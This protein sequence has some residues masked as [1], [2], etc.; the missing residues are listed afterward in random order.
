MDKKKIFIV[1]AAYNEGNS[2]AKVIGDLKSKGYRNIVVVDD[3]SR[4]NTYESA[5][6]AGAIVLRHI[7]NRGQGAGLKT[8]I[9]HALQ[10]NADIIVTYDADGQFL[11]S[12]I[13]RVADPVAKGYVDVAIGSR[14]LGEARNIPKLK[15]IVLKMGTF[16]LKLMY[17][18]NVTDSQNGFRAFSRNA[19]QQMEI[20]ADRME[21]A[22]EIL[23]EIAK[24][25]MRFI[26]IPVTV[27]YN[28]YALQKGQSWTRFAYL[29]TKLVL[30][31]LMR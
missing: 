24:K 9:D 12:E 8:G 28:D 5:R 10:M 7:I 25:Q 27:I 4:D 13:D 21:H 23:G 19:A 17:G 20:S 18:I 16:F 6:S 29:G 1:I 22:S 31:R 30:R 3:G 14:F 2:I 15:K 11:A 26:E